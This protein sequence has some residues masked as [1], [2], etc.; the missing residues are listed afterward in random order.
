MKRLKPILQS[1]YLFKLLVVIFLL[2]AFL[3]T[4]YYSFASKYSESE[5][6]FIGTVTDY[7]LKN[8]KLVLEVK[9]KEK[10]IV[11]YKYKNLV[12]NNL[13]YGDKVLIKGK[14][15]KPVE[16]TNFNT[17]DYQKYLYNKKIYWI[18]NATSID[19]LEN[20]SNYLYTVKNIIY[21]KINKLKSS[22]YIKALL[23]G[24]N[25]LD[26]EIKKSYRINGISHLFSIS[27]MHL[28]FIT[29]IIYCYLDKVTHNKTLKYLIVD[30]IL[31]LYL[32]LVAS[33]S[34]L[35]CVIMNILFSLN[36]I[37]K[38]NIKKI[39]LVLLTLIIGIIINPFII[40]DIGFIYSYLI[41]FF[42]IIFSGKTRSK[43]K[44]IK[45]INVTLISFLVSFPITAYNSYEV[46]IF[47][48]IINIL[49]V[50]II[51]SII[52][53][54]S[55]FALIFPIFD[56]ILSFLTNLLEEFSLF[57]SNINF[58]R[59]ILCKPNFILII[60]YYTII[61]LILNKPK[62]FY[63]FIIL[64]VFHLLLPYFNSNLEITMFD[65]GQGDSILISFPYNRGNILIDTGE[66]YVNYSN[67]QN[68]IIPYLKSTGK[69]KLDYLIITHGDA[70]H[71][72]GAITLV[73]NF[74][75]DKVILNRGDYSILEKNLI[76][77]LN[78]RKINCISDID[79]ININGHYM[80]LLN[81]KIFDNENDNSTIIYFEHQK[82]KFLFMGDASFNVEDYLLQKY[83]LYNISFLKVGHH[84]SS[85]SSSK[86]FIN[87]IN[88]KYSLISV[89]KNNRYGHPKESVLNTLSN[90]KIYRTDI[91][92]SIKI[93]LNKNRYK[94]I[95][96]TS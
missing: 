88:P 48:I 80:Y 89:G 61:I 39:D 54:L 28:N 1:K 74:K 60:I 31:I 84:G 34:L 83:N 43:K 46:N 78:K 27:G 91:N 70:D 58:L 3:F 24:D 4:K 71:I 36:F 56:E 77:I 30:A 62:Y 35:R 81:N 94:I 63:L 95:T 75:V 59:L 93:K 87:S 25:T 69:K 15:N 14:L 85:T 12:F 65:V 20:N 67:V 8:N 55:I 22:S 6:T 53:P 42:L 10:I 16:S 82:Y 79:K 33:S 32:L 50:P 96:Y 29:S 21:K 57:I 52:L 41:S 11:N 73:D 5:N 19:K 2:Y 86:D 51:S 76:T 26:K 18:I 90:T 13:S 66:E 45:V 9:A 7:E 40:Y 23:L 49:L 92:G 72:G 68:V 17:F 64:V 38:L 37:F 47:S 44:I